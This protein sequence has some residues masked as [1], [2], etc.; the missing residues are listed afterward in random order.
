MASSEK[1]RRGDRCLTKKVPEKEWN[2]PRKALRKDLDPEGT[3]PEPRFVVEVLA[4]DYRRGRREEKRGNGGGRG[5]FKMDPNGNGR[6]M[7][8]GAGTARGKR[9]SATGPG[10][11]PSDPPLRRADSPSSETVRSLPPG[12]SLNLSV[13]R[14]GTRT[15]GWRGPR[16]G[17]FAT[18]RLRDPGGGRRSPI[19]SGLRPATGKCHN[20]RGR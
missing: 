20:A 8:D 19:G 13:P 11:K 14:S 7:A 10:E 2:E 18:A 9:F 16:G 6:L 5:W 15:P 1:C 3:M 17:A 12:Q 4:K